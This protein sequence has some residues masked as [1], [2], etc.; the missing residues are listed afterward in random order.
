MTLAIEEAVVYGYAPDNDSLSRADADYTISGGDL[1]SIELSQR[2]EELKDSASF[3]VDNYSGTFTG[4]IDHG[5]RVEVYLARPGAGDADARYGETQYGT[6][7]YTGDALEHWWTGRVRSYTNEANGAENYRLSFEA[8]DFVYGVL[9]SRRLWASYVDKP[10]HGSTDA[11]LNDALQKK[12]PAIGRD[13][14]AADSGRTDIKW[15]GRTLLDLLKEVLARGGVTAASDGMDLIVKDCTTEVPEFTIGKGTGDWRL[16]SYKSNDDELINDLRVS[17]GVSPEMDDSVDQ[18]ATTEVT[19]NDRITARVSTR[20]SSLHS[21]DL[22]TEDTSDDAV[23]VRLQKDD[24]GAPIAPNDKKSDIVSEQIQHDDLNDGGWTPFELPNHT[25][26]EPNP[27]LLVES[28]DT[29][30]QTVGTD[31]SGNPAFRAYF[32]FP[33]SVEQQMPGSVSEYGRREGRVTDESLRTSTA[34][35]DHADAVLEEQSTPQETVSFVAASD[36]TH[37]L[38][39]A[40]V[41]H[42][43]DPRL[44]VDGT[45]VVTQKDE[46]IGGGT[47]EASFTCESL[48][49]L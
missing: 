13:Q 48:G 15:N 35:Y 31:G 39:V 29:D 5:D 36:R 41:V 2:G 7:Q 11:I 23:L 37:A 16:P 43:D 17:G 44:G 46:Q 34:A 40:E 20:V 14:I 27:W 32:P 6:S 4:R 18:S 9:G 25:L 38:D 22:Y 26:P 28:T 24:G 12:A 3:E 45:F 1:L 19:K 10:L 21:I 30:G 47:V 49:S 8:E 42:I 33:V